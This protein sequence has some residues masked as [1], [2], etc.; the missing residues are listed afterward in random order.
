MTDK[1]CPHGRGSAECCLDPGICRTLVPSPAREVRPSDG[2]Q[3]VPHVTEDPLQPR[4]GAHE[5]YMA[6]SIENQ[7]S[8]QSA[9]L[10]DALEWST[11]Y[12]R[13]NS[14]VWMNACI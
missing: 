12:G 10:A 7:M 2:I 3:V 9:C 14:F 8:A 4:V 13:L 5:K 6:L 1:L 11:T